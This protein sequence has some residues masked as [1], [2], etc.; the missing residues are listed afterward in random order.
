ML[1]IKN[2]FVLLLLVF[3]VIVAGQTR[4]SVVFKDGL[5]IRLNRA[6]LKDKI[7]SPNAVVALIETGKWKTPKEGEQLKYEDRVA[8]TWKKIEADK[9]GWIRNDTLTR[10]YVYYQYKSDKDDIALLEAMGNETAYVNGTARSGNPYRY[11]DTFEAWAPR[12][13]YSLIP[14]K[15]KKGTN[16]LLFECNRG[17]L[18][19]KLHP[20]KKGFYLTTTDLTVPDI[21]VNQEVNTYGAVPI[22]NATEGSYKNLSL[23]TWADGSSPEYHPVNE[24]G[25]LSIL[26]SPFYIKLPVQHNMGKIQF[27]IELVKKENLKKEVLTSSVIELN[28]V[29]PGDTHKETFISDIDGSVQYYAVNPPENLKGKPALFL[30]LHGAGVEAIN[31]AQAYAHKN[32]GYIVAPTNRR[33]YGYNWENWG[34]IDALEVLKIA[35][36]KFDIDPERV[37]LTGHSMGGHGAWQLGVNYADQFAAV[38][39]SAGW[40]SIWSYRIKPA[41]DSTGIAKML[42]RSTKQSD[43]YAFTTN[44]KSDGIYIIQGSLDDNVPPQQA[45]SMVENL[46]KFHKDF[47]Y[48][49]QPGAGHWWDNSDEP[50]AD[51]V[52]WAPMFDFFAHH[53]V[54]NQ[55]QVKIIDFVTANPAVTAKNYWIEIINQ[56]HQQKLS[57]INIRLESGLRKFVGTTDN[58]EYF[59]IDASMLTS[60]K[61][62]SIDLDKQTLA[63]VNIPQDGKIFLHNENGK[64]SL[65]G[66]PN[67]ENKYPARCG[68]MREAFNHNVFFVVGTHGSKKENEWAFKKARYDAEKIWYRGNSGIEI[69][70]DTEFNP[71]NYK[72][73]SV[74]LFGNSKTNSAWNLLLKDS[75]VQVD[76]NKIMVG[77]KEYKG[78]DLACL[79]VRPRLDSKIAC[80]GAITGTGVEG[81][82]LVNLAQYFDQYLG[83]PDV[84]IYN[85]GILKSDEKGIKFAGYFGND[86]SMDK[87]EFI[88]Q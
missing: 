83:F 72:D 70:K 87:G 14:V 79:L 2:V 38:G 60:G 33:P 77:N 67:E 64:W 40:I 44:L 58:I 9:D 61:P 3:S 51:C 27:H 26:K 63:D 50:G 11:Q 34:R 4:D 12:F 57:K 5:V 66:K 23:K 22:V 56:I 84:V 8:G 71:A 29:N 81:M 75:P 32:W 48:Y 41:P 65:A 49:V 85:S 31:Q 35:K 73:R 74:I 88:S 69:I 39:P 43:T 10:S 13:D 46:S 47:I 62:V 55:N 76:E 6:E 68:N 36:D 7:I 20:N 78:D 37:Y 82:E 17:L 28:V 86:W 25:P 54:A 52:D 19:V 21:I 24:I 18:K 42:T 16:E 45:E 1:K 15:I 53:A 59:S 80:V 30:S